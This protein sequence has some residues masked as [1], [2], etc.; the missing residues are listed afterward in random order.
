MSD[1]F[2][3]VA[4]VQDLPSGSKKTYDIRGKSVL[5]ANIAGK[6]YA[7]GA[8][9]NHKKWDLSEGRLEGDYIVCV[10][11]GSKWNLKTGAGVFRRPLPP[12]PTYEVKIEDGFIYVKV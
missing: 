9:C 3:K 6:I 4:S 2:V 11:H 1:S 7:I 8:I 12:E 5:L 10:G